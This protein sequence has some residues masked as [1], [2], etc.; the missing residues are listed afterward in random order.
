MNSIVGRYTF[1]QFGVDCL[2]LMREG[3]SWI[4]VDAE[5]DPRTAIVRESY[6]TPAIRS[7]ICVPLMKSGRLVAALSVHRTEPHQWGPE[8][9]ELVQLVANRCWEAIERAYVTRE[10]KASEQRLRLAQKA[11]RIGSFEWRMK[12][13]RI[14]WS[15][16]LE[17]LYGVPEGAFEGSLDHWIRRVVAEDAERVLLQIQ[18]CV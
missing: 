8:E 12:E 9:V 2:R 6:Q 10:L 4:V 11:G 7:I 17:A 3:Q 18:S 1:S 14:N 16:E 5:T 15:P 13:N